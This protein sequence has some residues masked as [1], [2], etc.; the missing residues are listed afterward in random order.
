MNPLVKIV[1]LFSAKRS[2]QELEMSRKVFRLIN[3]FY[4]SGTNFSQKVPVARRTMR[5]HFFKFSTLLRLIGLSA[6]SRFFCL[7]KSVL[8]FSYIVGTL[9]FPETGEGNT[10]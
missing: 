7:D 9:Q 5:K 4:S 10:F 2:F 8:I 6:R 3:L 1:F